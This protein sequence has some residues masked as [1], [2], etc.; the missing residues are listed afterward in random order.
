MDDWSYIECTTIVSDG[1]EEFVIHQPVIH[2]CIALKIESKN[3]F[4]E[5]L[6]WNKIRDGL[7]KNYKK[8][9]ETFAVFNCANIPRHANSTSIP[10]EQS[11]F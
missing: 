7:Q 10:I 11:I 8:I 9:L 5:N 4:D 3:E 1:C 6:L 2:S